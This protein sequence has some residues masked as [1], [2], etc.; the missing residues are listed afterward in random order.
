M[1]IPILLGG[2]IL[3]LIVMVAYLVKPDESFVTGDIVRPEI[4]KDYYTFVAFY[5]TFLVNWEK[6]IITSYGLSLPATTDASAR[7]ATSI[8][9]ETLNAHITKISKEKN[10][11]FPPL[12]EALPET[13][14]QPTIPLLLT[15]VPA[16][17]APYVNALTWMNNQLSTAQQSLSN[18]MKGSVEGFIWARMKGLPQPLLNVPVHEGFYATCDQIAKCMDARDEAKQAS[19]EEELV[20]RL[21]SFTQNV[22][23][24]TASTQN[25][26]LVEKSERLQKQ[27]E[28]GEL[29]NQFNLPKEPVSSPLQPPEGGDRL[30]KLKKSDPAAYKRLQQESGSMFALK[31]LLEQ[32]NRTV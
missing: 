32:I 22:P 10:M 28:S 21:R 5:K 23:L 4:M 2:I 19:Q 1:K 16:D 6:A 13:L 25:K 9:R 17:A 27:A 18:M 12:T 29:L 11:A 7:S 26:V 24:E 8:P 30:S 3:V 14:A 31:G 15:L 20:R